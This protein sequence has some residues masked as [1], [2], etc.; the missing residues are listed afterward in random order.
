MAEKQKAPREKI[1]DKRKEAISTE[2]QKAVENK[3]LPRLYF[4]GFA[5]TLSTGDVMLVLK[6]NDEPVAILNTSYTVAKTLA[7][8]LEGVIVILEDITGN[9]I[10]TTEQIENAIAEGGED[11]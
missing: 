10:M 5:T 8:K 4:N 1:A 6:Q 2:I 3:E 11:E 7:Q 9:T